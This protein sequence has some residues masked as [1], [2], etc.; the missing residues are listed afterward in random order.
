M[1]NAPEGWHGIFEPGE[2]IS[3]QGRPGSQII[4]RDLLNVQT[5][6]GIFFAL[7]SLAWLSGV[8]AITSDMPNDGFVVFT[9]LFP[10]VG[11]VFFLVGLYQSFGRLFWDAYK[12]SNTWYTL[13]NKAAYIA[14]S[15]FGHRQLKRYA[16]ERFDAPE[17]IDTQPGTV[18]FTHEMREASKHSAGSFELRVGTRASRGRVARVK[19]GFRCID[20]ARRVYGLIRDMS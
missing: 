6:M 11:G 14:S 16:A 10:L 13:T 1:N 20:D 3:W 15:T 12:R 2:E 4:W 17:L 19:I 5:G 8:S 7:F 9:L 18:W